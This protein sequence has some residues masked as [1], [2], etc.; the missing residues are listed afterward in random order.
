MT[1]FVTE[2]R[3]WVTPHIEC[4]VDRDLDSLVARVKF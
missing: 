4:K 1:L 2:T 3:L